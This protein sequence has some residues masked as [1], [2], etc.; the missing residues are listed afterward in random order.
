MKFKTLTTKP[1]QN[2]L[3]YEIIN[4][5]KEPTAETIIIKTLNPDYYLLLGKIKLIITENG[6]A[7]SHLAIVAR[8]QNIPVLLVEN[9]INNIPEKG[10]LTI[11]NETVKIN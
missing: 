5:I 6:S 2:N 9:I 3:T 11:K 8:E 10:S 1:L 7:L 4:K